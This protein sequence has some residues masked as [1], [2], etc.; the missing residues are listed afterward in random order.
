MIEQELERADRKYYI[1]RSEGSLDD[2]AMSEINLAIL[3]QSGEIDDE[4]TRIDAMTPFYKHKMEEELSPQQRRILF[5]L[6]Q[7]G[8]PL[9]VWEITQYAR[10]DQQNRA[11]AQVHRLFEKG[12]LEKV[13]KGY[14][15][16]S[17][18]P[19]FLRFCV[20]RWTD[21]ALAWISPRSEELIP[22]RKNPISYFIKHRGEI[23]QA[24]Y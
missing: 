18:D 15:L 7:E 12:Y 11:S 16:S 13:G 5:T 4:L 22:D 9:R 23:K 24:S 17:K 10:L 20:A 14:Y 8:R 6:V 1:F 21:F 3:R 19:D 2:L